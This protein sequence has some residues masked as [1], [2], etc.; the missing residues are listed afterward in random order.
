M[1]ISRPRRGEYQPKMW[2]GRWGSTYT[3]DPPSWRTKLADAR[4][5]RGRNERL[6]G[7]GDGGRDGVRVAVAVDVDHP[8][9]R[10][11]L[12]GAQVG[13]GEAGLEALVVEQLGRAAAGAAPRR[14]HRGGDVED[15]GDVR[16]AGEAV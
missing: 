7:L 3:R 2:R 8:V 5:A 13:G 12:L 1:G 9:A 6:Q 4:A 15:D 11:Q 16:A 10:D 14:G